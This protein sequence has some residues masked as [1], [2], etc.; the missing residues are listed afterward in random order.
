MHKQHSDDQ[1]QKKTKKRPTTFLGKVWYFI[2]D[3]DSVL[4]WLVNLVLA[5]ILIKFIV[6][7]GLGFLLGT[8]HP[9]VAVV[10]GSMDHS[11]DERGM[12]CG[13]VPPEY[14]GS[15]DDFWNACGS[16]YLEREITKDMFEEFI[17]KNGFKKG[18]IIVLLGT[19]P[20]EIDVGD[21]I[22]FQAGQRDPIIHRVVRRWESDGYL[23]QT[24]GDHNAMSIDMPQLNEM[25]ISQ[26]RIIGKAIFRIPFLGN[27]KIWF[28][29][30]LRFLKIDN[31]VGVLFN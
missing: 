27:I 22:V 17:F 25:E 5:F 3:D 12:I 18:D 2:W 7:P 13:N 4:S 6:Y 14:K 8:T 26:E 19:K 24:K 29:D 23:F 1:K 28:V 21:V 30:F 31:S 9:V 10:S 15:F 20:A 11:L 16:F